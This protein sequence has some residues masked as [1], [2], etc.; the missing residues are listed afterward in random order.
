[1]VF[2][3]LVLL[4]APRPGPSDETIGRTLSD[5]VP[6][7]E[8]DRFNRCDRI[9]GFHRITGIRE[10]SPIIDPSED[11]ENRDNQE[12]KVKFDNT[13]NHHPHLHRV[14]PELYKYYKICEGLSLI[15]EEGLEFAEEGEERPSRTNPYLVCKNERKVALDYQACKGLVSLMDGFTY[16]N[17]SAQKIQ[18]IDQSRSYEKIR[19]ETW[20]KTQMGDNTTTQLGALEAS[21]RKQGQ[22][23]SQKATLKSGEALALKFKIRSFPTRQKVLE[24]CPD[25]DRD[26][27]KYAQSFRN[28][29][30]EVLAEQFKIGRDEAKSIKE[31]LEDK[32]HGYEG[33]TPK[34][35]KEALKKAFEDKKKALKEAL[36]DKIHG[37]KP[38]SNESPCEMSMDHFKKM[39][40]NTAVL[41][42]AKEQFFNSLKD[43][44]LHTVQKLLS[45][46]QAN[47]I[48]KNIEALNN[49]KEQAL[50]EEGF[51]P[52][53][54]V[55]ECVVNPLIPA[56]RSQDDPIGF[57]GGGFDFGGP[58]NSGTLTP[59]SQEKIPFLPEDDLEINV[60][61]IPIPRPTKGPKSTL[62]DSVRGQVPQ[63][64][65]PGFG[66]AGGAGSGGGPGGGA[67]A[68]GSSGGV[69]GK[70]FKKKGGRRSGR[71][72]DVKGNFKGGGRLFGI[73]NSRKKKSNDLASL[74]KK[75][76]KDK[77]NN[78]ILN[79]RLPA[80]V[81]GKEDNL[82]KR[83]SL[84][85]DKI[86]GHKRLIEYEV[87]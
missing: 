8:L 64:S 58:G 59:K 79:Y 71:V 87:K 55:N 12:F 46:R 14:L 42:A 36:K 41:I 85:Y 44:A 49:R 67:G 7:G 54:L 21:V 48:S 70:D 29:L 47:R 32:I 52:D 69:S 33:M 66:R 84:R 76:T 39:F 20:K 19:A 56:C 45:D 23:L 2:S 68:S 15:E 31:A 1:M 62:S 75:D 4:A 25:S 17:I 53:L 6:G 50:K 34:D 30:Q 40:Q 38:T 60:A 63:G 16:A 18:E 37:Y 61:D 5:I 24:L 10:I 77:I 9:N 11:S 22:H 74:F 51:D 13:S 72:S 3:V 78:A 83:I 73:G 81:K 65:R 82:F 26:E 57:S 43:T 28:N 80:S 27:D 86:K 35:K